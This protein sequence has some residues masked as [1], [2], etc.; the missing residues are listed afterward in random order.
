MKLGLSPFEPFAW[1][2]RSLST[3]GLTTSCS[4][5]LRAF[6]LLNMCTRFLISGVIEVPSVVLL[7]ALERLKWRSTGS[8]KALP[9]RKMGAKLEGS[10]EAKSGTKE[11]KF[12]GSEDAAGA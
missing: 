8:N 3:L 10:V 12:R 11:A 6:F 5:L 1:V 4:H 2:R 9:R 7:S